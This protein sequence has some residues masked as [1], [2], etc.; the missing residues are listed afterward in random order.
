LHTDGFQGWRSRFLEYYQGAGVVLACSAVE[1][2]DQVA[3]G[4]AG[5][6]ELIVAV[7][8]VLAAVE[9][10]LF[11]FGDSGAKAAD[12][13]DLCQPGL[14]GDLVAQKLGQPFGEFGY[15]AA[16]AF[17][18]AAQ[19]SDVGERRPSA[20]AG[21]RRVWFGCVGECEDL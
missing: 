16:E 1:R 7:V 14:V 4:G 9:E 3:V 5:G 10:L 13:V 20:D 18:M 8:E 17:V 19:V 11:E 21:A 12:F 6:G 15:L 2:G